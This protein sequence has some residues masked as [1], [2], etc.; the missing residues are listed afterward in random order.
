MGQSTTPYP[1]VARGGHWDDEDVTMLRSAV[2]R[3]SD[4]SWK[5]QDP[6]CPR[7][8]G[9]TPTRSSSLPRHPATQRAVAGGIAEGLEQRRGED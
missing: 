5:Q 7:A 4:K 8:S 2:R 6:N 1:H 3:S 9:I